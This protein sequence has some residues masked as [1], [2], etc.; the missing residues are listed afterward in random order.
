MSTELAEVRRKPISVWNWLGTILVAFVPLI[1][2]V[3]LSYWSLSKKT[4]PNRRNFSIAGLITIAIWIALIL[5]LFFCVYAASDP[6]RR[7]R[8]FMLMDY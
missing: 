3:V 7:I 2:V 8:A 6:S 4:D 1:N 5:A